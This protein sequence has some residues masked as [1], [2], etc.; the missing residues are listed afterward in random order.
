[1]WS[2]LPPCWDNP[3]IKGKRSPRLVNLSYSCSMTRKL[4]RQQWPFSVLMLQQQSPRKW[5]CVADHIPSLPSFLFG[6]WFRL[7]CLSPAPAQCYIRLPVQTLS[8]LPVQA[9]ESGIALPFC[10]SSPV[11]SNITNI[12]TLSSRYANMLKALL[13]MKENMSNVLSWFYT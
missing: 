10:L 13:K 3:W 11:N 12:Y 7:V 1:M 6:I 5:G 8:S 2:S 9:S 4:K